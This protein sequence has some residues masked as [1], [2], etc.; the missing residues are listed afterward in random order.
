MKSSI[1]MCVLY[2]TFKS[3]ASSRSKTFSCHIGVC[4]QFSLLKT[5]ASMFKPLLNSVGL[6][7]FK[8]PN[9][10]YFLTRRKNFI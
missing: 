5:I 2:I 9:I 7:A 8:K 6:G 4:L 1:E 10:N 3:I